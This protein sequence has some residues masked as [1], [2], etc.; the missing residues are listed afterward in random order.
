MQFQLENYAGK[1]RAL[2]MVWFLY[3]VYSVLKGMAGLAF[4]TLSCL[5]TSATGV[6]AR[7]LTA[8]CPRSG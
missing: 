1:V 3:A 5:T 8:P 4:S 2:S 6:T 7:G